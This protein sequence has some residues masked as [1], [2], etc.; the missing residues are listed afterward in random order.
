MLINMYLRLLYYYVHFFP[1]FIV[2]VV[3][4]SSASVSIV[5]ALSALKSS[6][7]KMLSCRSYM[8][9]TCISTFRILHNYHHML[10]V[11]TSACVLMLGLLLVFLLL[12]GI[13]SHMSLPSLL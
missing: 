10:E 12:L 11:S 8:L 3:S 6:C 7:G 1:S 13:L 2:V 5:V 4:S 9:K